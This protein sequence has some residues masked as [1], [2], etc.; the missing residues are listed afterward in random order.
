M[1]DARRE[2]PEPTYYGAPSG[3]LGTLFMAVFGN[4]TVKRR[5]RPVGGDRPSERRQS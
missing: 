1:A 3:L 2:E 4:V 5:G